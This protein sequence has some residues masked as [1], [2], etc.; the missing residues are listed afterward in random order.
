MRLMRAVLVTLPSEAVTVAVW[1]LE[2]VPA[3]ALN[4]AEA[5][6]VVT[7]T[8]AGTV[9]AMLLPDS[10]T[11]MPEG[12]AELSVAVQVEEVFV[13]RLVGLHTSVERVTSVPV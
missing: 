11:V 5:A 8:D 2:M 12:A 13:F 9:R 1:L 4:V 6:P 7:V 10:K 3:A